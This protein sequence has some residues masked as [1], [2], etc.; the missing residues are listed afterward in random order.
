[1]KRQFVT[2]MLAVTAVAA[3]ACGDDDPAVERAAAAPAEPRPIEVE[4]GEYFFRAPRQLAPG[5]AIMRLRNVGKETHQLA[6]ARL[7]EGVSL[8][9]AIAAGGQGGTATPVGEVVARPGVTGELR[10]DLTPG[11]YALICFEETG[12][13]PHFA[14]GQKSVFEVS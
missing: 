13:E 3:A 7:A 5:P 1:M 12:G 4:A 11:R 2:V 9:R 14:R 8:E 6:V 10:V